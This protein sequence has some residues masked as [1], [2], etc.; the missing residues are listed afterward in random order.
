MPWFAPHDMSERDLRAIYRYIKS[1]G[2]AGGP[3]P[4]FV[5]PGREP[6]EPYVLFPQPPK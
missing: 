5:P 3:A 6:K 4:A 1:L 2:P